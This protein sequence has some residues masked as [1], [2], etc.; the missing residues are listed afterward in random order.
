MPEPEQK[1]L[2]EQCILLAKKL[3]KYP[4]L[5][6]RTHED[7]KKS[8]QKHNARKKLSEELNLDYIVVNSKINSIIGQYFREIRKETQGCSGKYT[9]SKYVSKW[10]LLP[11]L[12]Y[13]QKRTDLRFTQ[14]SNNSLESMLI[15]EYDVSF[16]HHFTQLSLLY[17]Y[18]VL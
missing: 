4:E 10:Y 5:W 6:D 17:F 3:E 8:T 2:P 1:L 11:Y 7:Y 16:N 18:I 13:M 12:K 9:N 15:T 14:N